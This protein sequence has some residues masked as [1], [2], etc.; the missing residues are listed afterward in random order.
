MNK[1]VLQINQKKNI[2]IKRKIKFKTLKIFHNKQKMEKLSISKKAQ[3]KKKINKNQ[4]KML[5]QIKNCKKKIK[6]S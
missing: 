3:K 2:I 6:I 1:K 4:I 5:V